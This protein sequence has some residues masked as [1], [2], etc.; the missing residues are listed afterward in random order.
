VLKDDL[1]PYTGLSFSAVA[2]AANRTG[3]PAAASSPGN[4][5]EARFEP[6]Q[7][8][9]Y[10]Q[11]TLAGL[12]NGDV[13]VT[14]KGA[15]VQRL[16]DTDPTV[17]L[18]S[19]LLKIL[20]TLNAERRN[21]NTDPVTLENVAQAGGGFSLDVQYAD[22]LLSRLPKIQHVERTEMQL[23]FFAD[24]KAATTQLAHWSFLGLFALVITLEWV[25]R[26][27]AGLV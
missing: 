3:T 5:V 25:V 12:P 9:G 27:M 13:E 24:P 23:G 19:L 26:K 8:P 16:L 7:S 1:T 21:M 17:T 6:M 22:L 2:R 14:L 4:G 10:Y 18:R 15:E 11:A 20:P